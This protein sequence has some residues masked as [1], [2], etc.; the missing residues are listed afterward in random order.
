MHQ[1]IKLLI[2]DDEVQFLNA[3]ARRLEIR[4]FCITKATNGSEAIKAASSEKFDMALLDLKMPGMD[5]T[6]VLRILKKEHKHLE[7]II[8]TGHGSSDSAVK[9]T[10]LGAYGYVPK[11]YELEQLIQ[12]LKDAF[13]KR[14]MKKFQMNGEKMAEIMKIEDDDNALRIIHRLKELDDGVR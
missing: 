13:E 3:L 1:K 7:V 14:I 6:E 5:G 8:L 11:P 2:V 12:I 4:G 9:C 10:Q